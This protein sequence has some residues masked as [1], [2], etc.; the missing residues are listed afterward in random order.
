MERDVI[1]E[2]KMLGCVDCV[3]AGVSVNAEDASDGEEWPAAE[4][5]SLDEGDVI[6]YEVSS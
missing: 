6:H 5:T 2:A 1:V 3:Q 4:G